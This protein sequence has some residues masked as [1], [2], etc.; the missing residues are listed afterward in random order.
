LSRGMS[1]AAALRAFAACEFG[2]CLIAALSPTLYYNGFFL[3]GAEWLQSRGMSLSLTFLSLIPPTALMGMC[4]PLLAHA[5]SSRIEEAAARVSQL[6]AVNILGAAM[7]CLGSGWYLIG[8]FGYSKAT[9]IGCAV[10]LMV[11]AS[12]WWLS[13][14]ASTKSAESGAGREPPTDSPQAAPGPAENVLRWCLLM[15]ASGFVAIS[16][17]I[18]WFRI[19]SMM[20]GTLPYIFSL[21]LALVLVGYSLGGLLASR[22]LKFI[23]DPFSAFLKVQAWVLLV[24]IGSLLLVVVLRPY[25]PHSDVYLNTP[26]CRPFGGVLGYVTRLALAVLLLLPPNM[27]IGA[28]FP[29]SQAALLRDRASVGKL[30]AWVQGANIFGNLLASLVTGFVFFNWYGTP[31]TLRILAVIGLVFAGLSIFHSRKLTGHGVA[32]IVLLGT[33]L[34]SIPQT[35][36]W[37]RLMHLYKAGDAIVTAEDQSGVAVMARRGDEPFFE[38]FASG[39]VQGHTPKPDEHHFPAVLIHEAPKTMLCIGLGA[40]ASVYANACHPALQEITVCEILRSMKPMMDLH[41]AAHPEVPPHSLM[42]SDPRFHFR[43]QDGRL[44]L[45]ADQEKKKYDFI[46]GYPMLPYNSR[47][48]LLFS[49]EFFG[50]VSSRL[51]PGGIAYWLNGSVRMRRTFVSQFKYV[52][53]L[54]NQNILG[55]DMPLVPRIESLM[56]RLST[57]PQAVEHLKRSGYAPLTHVPAIVQHWEPDTPREAG[58]VN[59]DLQ[60]KDEYLLNNPDREMAAASVGH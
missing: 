2:V 34:A 30:V 32:L 51:S 38:M 35:G 41:A 58:E 25:I 37:W 9:Y 36:Q 55:S 8:K 20:I 49:R 5:T 4:F 15:A 19:L 56:Q 46:Y 53:L 50:L 21:M 10:S 3:S 48:G 18:V 12:A 6:N 11:A 47:S 54:E 45:L 23:C 17:E 59:T 22:R 27:L 40:G 42:L 28:G 26:Q 1:G 7:G 31:G 16:L 24:S 33:T 52:V 29:L 57:M 43:Y 44:M 14:Q 39:Q 13:T 60:P